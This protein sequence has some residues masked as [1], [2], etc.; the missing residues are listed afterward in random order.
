MTF[1][2][3]DVDPFLCT[4][5]I[6]AFGK[7]VGNNIDAYEWNDKGTGGKNQYTCLALLSQLRNILK[8]S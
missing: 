7:V 6:Y 3:D 4:H 5:I 1:T 8:F 2:A